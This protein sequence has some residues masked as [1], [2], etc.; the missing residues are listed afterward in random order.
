MSC[1][2]LVF[3]QRT[4]LQVPLYTFVHKKRHD[5]VIFQARLVNGQ[6]SGPRRCALFKNAGLERHKLKKKKKT[7]CSCAVALGINGS[8]YDIEHPI[9]K[10]VLKDSYEWGDE[11]CLVKEFHLKLILAFRRMLTSRPP[12]QL[13]RLLLNF[14]V[15]VDYSSLSHCFNYRRR[16]AHRRA[17][18]TVPRET[19]ENHYI[20]EI[21]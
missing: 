4:V 12:R 19:H 14:A 21:N 1:C 2:G 20:G 8:L 7:G 5:N 10:C 11:G 18:E 15:N 3:K 13:A 6:W 17:A 9:R 16:H